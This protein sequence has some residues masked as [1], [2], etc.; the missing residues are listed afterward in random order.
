MKLSEIKK[1]LVEEINSEQEQNLLVLVQTL[2]DGLTQQ[3]RDKY[4]HA[5]NDYYTYKVGKKYIKVI[6]VHGDSRGGQQS[7]W[8]FINRAD[9][10]S[11]KGITF[12]CGDVLKSAGWA[13]P[14]LNAPRGNLFENGDEG[15]VITGMRQY[16][17]DYLR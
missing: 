2:C 14:A 9:F 6:S 1:R 17:P 11:P 10:T 3:I 16:G 8:G 15:Y 13:T 7:V 5:V 12:K 4:K